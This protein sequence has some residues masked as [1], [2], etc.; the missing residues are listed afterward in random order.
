MESNNGL[1][2]LL[3]V[4]GTTIATVPTSHTRRACWWWGYY[5]LSLSYQIAGMIHVFSTA[6]VT[7]E[8]N[9]TLGMPKESF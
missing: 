2:S 7:I 6:K 4:G 1:Q 9:S 8:E 3:P 5:V